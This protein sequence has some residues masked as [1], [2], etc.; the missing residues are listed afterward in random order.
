MLGCGGSAQPLVV[1]EDPRLELAQP[2]PGFDAELGDELVPDPPVGR[3]GVGLAAR[4]VQS[5]YQQGP[6]VFA[7]RM[8]LRELRQRTDG[9]PRVGVG[10]AFEVRLDSAQP[11]FGQSGDRR[12]EAGR[13]QT[14]Q[15]SPAPVGKGP[16]EVTVADVPLKARHVDRV[17]RHVEA[18]RGTDPHDRTGTKALA[19]LGDVP[20]QGLVCRPRGRVAPHELHQARHRQRCPRRQGQCGEHR[21]RLRRTDVDRLTAVGSD[22][23]TTEQTDP[24]HRAAPRG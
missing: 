9:P 19:Q 15:G 4:P 8:A 2:R 1:V 18:V 6:D 3:E 16:A 7:E 5:G 10:T 22:A 20:L 13:V 23:D 14:G 12:G 17:R 21:L 11:L 24:H